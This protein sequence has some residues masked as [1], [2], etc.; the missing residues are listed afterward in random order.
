MTGQNILFYD[1]DI[2][3]KDGLNRIFENVSIFF[4]ITGNTCR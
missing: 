1:V 3:D 4:N 2:T